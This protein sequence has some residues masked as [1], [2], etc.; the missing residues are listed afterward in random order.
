MRR[1]APWIALIGLTLAG[2]GGSGGGAGG[3]VT[4][5]E[6]TLDA[7]QASVLTPYCAVS[8]CHVGSGAPF[9]LDL[10][11]G[12]AY[13]NLVDVPSAEMPAVDRVEP[14]DPA[15]SYLIWKVTA[16]P[17]IT[18]DPMPALREPLSAARIQLITDWIADGASP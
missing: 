9:G 6:A 3:T 17:R 8:G 2:C 10:S 5:P 7:V 13:G 16:D 4:P 15:S 1:P 12:E 18:G 11:A 14:G